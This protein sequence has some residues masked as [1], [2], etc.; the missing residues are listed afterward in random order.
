M[1]SGS[2]PE[3]DPLVMALEN[4]GAKFTS[5]FIK[6]KLLQEDLKKV[7]VRVILF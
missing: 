4:F 3:Y 1:L 7:W 5:D 6:G 2:P